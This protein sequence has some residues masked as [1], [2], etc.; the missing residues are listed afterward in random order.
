MA[1]K[2]SSFRG[3]NYFL[4]NFYPSFVEFEGLRYPAV[5]DAFQAAKTLD[6]NERIQFTIMPSPADAKRAG[7]HLKLRPDWEE[8]K[9]DI[10]YQIVKSKFSIPYLKSELLATGSAELE[11]GN[12]HGDR[13]WGTVAGEGRNELGKIL[14]KV[15]DELKEEIM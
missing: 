11:E 10:M 6:K 12:T 13:F 8:V 1:N 9:I 5:E 7:R 4:S 15:R 14:M 2:I 3:P